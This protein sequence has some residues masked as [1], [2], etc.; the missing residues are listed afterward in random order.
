MI[1]HV[2]SRANQA[3][4]I[5]ELHRVARRAVC[6][7]TPNR[8]FPIEVHTSMPLLHWLPAG[9]FRGIL[10]ATRLRFFADEANLN[11]LSASDLRKL[12]HRQGIAGGS[13][14]GVRLLGWTSNLLL[15][16]DKRLPQTDE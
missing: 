1:E 13:V 12:C 15:F 5:A 9:A 4:L 7:T 11:L 8:W 6:L 16:L 3:R 14:E 10:G 2:G